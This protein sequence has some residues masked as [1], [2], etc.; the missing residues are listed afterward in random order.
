[1]TRRLILSSA[2]ALSAVMSLVISPSPSEA[3]P[4]CNSMNYGIGTCFNN[5]W[6]N[7]DVLSPLLNRNRRQ[8]M[9]LEQP[10]FQPSFG[11]GYF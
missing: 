8:P 9:L 4:R 11:S 10:R 5:D 6:N 3:Y 2:F 1:M 7:N